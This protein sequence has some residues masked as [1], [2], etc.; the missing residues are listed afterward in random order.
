M[1]PERPAVA[2]LLVPLVV[3][4]EVGDELADLDLKVSQAESPIADTATRGTTIKVREA[5]SIR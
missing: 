4:D 2:P 5:D 3:G 1:V